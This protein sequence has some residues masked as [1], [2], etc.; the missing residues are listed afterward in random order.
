MNRRLPE[1]K[2]RKRALLVEGGGMKGAFAGGVLHA[3][4]CYLPA[5]H[6]DL[7]VAVSSGACC[8]AYYAST[9][10]PE[11]EIGDH[12]L[13]IWR[14][15]LAGHRLISIF[16][17]LRKKTLLDQEFLI[18]FLFAKKYPLQAENF[19]QY[20]LPEFRVAVTNLR[21]RSIEYV[22]ATES[23]I[24]PLL[25]AAT[26]L[27][28]ATR[29][30]HDVEGRLCSDAALLNPLP[31]NDL[32]ECGY[33]D[34]TVVM[35]SPSWRTSAPFN[36]LTGMLSFPRDWKMAKLMRRWH[37]HH[38]NLARSVASA[39][40]EGITIH[41]IAPEQFLP[42]GLVTTDQAKLEETVAMG[43]Q[44]GERAAKML[45]EHFNGQQK[46][47]ARNS[48]KGTKATKATRPSAPSAIEGKQRK[49]GQQPKN[50]GKA[51]RSDSVR[52][53]A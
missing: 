51:V 13:S 20:G 29:G 26:A 43:V 41:T 12:T 11:P 49:A 8:A 39:P 21:S 31:V 16:N 32:I 50:R 28:I 10:D 48:K 18:D 37:H 7:V 33:T 17:P 3:L 22:R 27:P 42:V 45:L 53:S 4:N 2:G 40:P 46:K 35:N 23:N 1:A 30:R 44:A 38:F 36:F 25:K 19:E 6:Y 52:Q 24:F 5:Q 14:H 9:P 47:S 34:I 15:E